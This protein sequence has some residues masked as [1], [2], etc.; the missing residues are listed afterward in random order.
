MSGAELAARRTAAAAVLGD[1]RR[2]ADKFIDDTT[3]TAPRPDYSMWAFRLSS[4]L[5]SVL[6]QLEAEATSAPAA[7]QPAGSLR[8]DLEATIRTWR[9][10][11]EPYPD[12]SA[13]DSA[14]RSG[15]GYCGDQLAQLLAQ[16]QQEAQPAPELAEVRPVLEVLDSETGDRQFALE[17]IDR[18]VNGDP[19]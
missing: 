15:F 17:Q 18:I 12:E 19:S 6:Q 3:R 4:E 2:A 13:T 16:H 8:T 9:E 11:S 1:F 10:E 7:P 5:A 14:R